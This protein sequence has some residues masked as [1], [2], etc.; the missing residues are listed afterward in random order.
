MVD[1]DDFRYSH[2]FV[3]YGRSAMR[4]MNPEAGSVGAPA[5]RLSRSR[6]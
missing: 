3:V 6:T 1:E 2:Q 5:R 4:V